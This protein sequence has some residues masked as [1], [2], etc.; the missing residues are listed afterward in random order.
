MR[1]LHGKV[2][3][4]TGA[5]S[6]IGRSMAGRFA[7]E[8]MKVVLADV[9]AGALAEAE[10]E[11]KSGGA[12]VLAVETDV[13]SGAAVEALAART[14]EVFG[15]AH[16]ICNNAG[17]GGVAGPLW[18]LTTADWDW[19]LRVN[20][21]GVIHGLRVFVPILLAQGGEG[22]IVNTASVAGLT[23]A[24]FMAAYC[25]TKHAVVTIS[26]VLSKDLQ[27]IDS[28]VKVSVLCPGFVRTRIAD[29]GRNRP[30]DLRNP[31]QAPPSS[32][33]M[34]MG[35]AVRQMVDAGTPPEMVA[36][37]VVAAIREER[38]YVL[39]HPEMKAGVQQRMDD[40]LGERT[41]EVGAMF[42]ALR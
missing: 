3:V 7:A 20:L 25:A 34:N 5:A 19:T 22:H 42:R 1:D 33:T 4:V 15:A 8:G 14:L 11:L 21:W 24:P 37:R 29:S 10:A 32:G 13:S 23:S 35:N 2:A 38:F 18:T 30:V 16:V 41:P 17:V 40:I 6:G 12:T 39:P 36:D 27:L 9:E 26:E 31:A 28:T